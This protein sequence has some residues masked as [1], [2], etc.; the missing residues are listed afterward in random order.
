MSA[1]NIITEARARILWGEE[2]SSVRDYLTENGF[3]CTDAD[4][5]IAEMTR[6]R[7]QQLRKIGMG[8]V[9]IG[10]LLVAVT[11]VCSY[12]LFMRPVHFKG[13]G[14]RFNWPLLLS[15][16]S[17]VLGVYGLWRLIRGVCYLI[18]PQAEHK[19]LSDLDSNE[20]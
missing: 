5:K 20:I 9:L 16:Y 10:G 14:R 18:R 1:E 12:F 17:L 19:S 6:E 2:S 11:G 8:D 15:E 13:T 4:I 7:N 3:S